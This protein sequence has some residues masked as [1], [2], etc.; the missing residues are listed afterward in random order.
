[1]R[2][3]A[4]ETRFRARA[5]A[6]YR[7]RARSSGG[8]PTPSLERRG[9]LNHRL[10][11]LLSLLLAVVV[12]PAAADWLT[13]TAPPELSLPRDHG[14]HPEVRTEWWYLT[15]IVRDEAGQRYGFQVTFFRQGLDPRPAH[16]G[17]SPLRVRHAVAAHLAVADVDRGRFRHAERIRRADDELAGFATDDLDVWLD[18]WRLRREA[19]DVLVAQGDDRAAGIGLE[20]RLAPAKPLVRQ[21]LDGYSRKGPEAGNA[22]AYLSWPR[23]A[24]TGALTLDGEP[25]AV[26]GEGWF[27][28]EWG[29][30]QLGPGV[31]G[32]DWFSLRLDDRSELMVYRLRRADG[33]PDELSS[34]TVI[35]TD[36][37]GRRLGV[38]DVQ[39]T[40]T[41]HWTSPATGAVYPS[42]WR[43]VVP[44]AGIDV[45]VTPL[46]AAA[47]LDG[48]ASTGVIYWEGPVAVAGSQSGE[49]YV[50]LTGYAGSLA[51]RF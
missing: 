24:V 44:G 31:V 41:D 46:L 16:A 20:L 10:A 18:T 1:M 15:G 38:D 2:R 34:G 25:R 22:S 27:D 37:S 4:L 51:G 47:E 50:E 40:V 28:H 7:F 43:L 8:A 45:E 36:G 30:S 29:S 32:W 5:R 19:G 17:D 9:D 6:R 26:S 21:G 42:G 23:L 3:A 39:L 12:V 49:G 11:L 35:A 48:S 14:A 13:I 33:T